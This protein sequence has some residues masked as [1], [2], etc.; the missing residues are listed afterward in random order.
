MQRF[1]SSS[2]G[3][4]RTVNISLWTLCILALAGLWSAFAMGTS[5]AEPSGRADI[6]TIDGLK[7]FGPLERAP[8][9]FLH[10]KHTEVVARQKKDCLVCHPMDGDRLSLR[11]QR[12][13]DVSRQQVMDLYHDQCIACH[14]EYRRLG[15]RSGPV[16]CGECH[17][18]GKTIKSDRR[19]IWLDRSLHYR[20]VKACQDK[21]ETCHHEYNA[22]TKKLY[23]AKGQEGACIYCHK[24]KTEENRISLRLADH[25]AC[26]GCHRNL[27]NEHKDAGPV[28][29]SGCHDPRKQALIKKVKDPPRIARNQPDA[30]LVKTFPPDEMPPASQERLTAVPFNHEAHEGYVNQCR[31]CHHA[32][33]SSC[34]GCHT[35]Q[36]SADGQMV[37]LAQAMHQPDA[38]MSC[39]GC[40]RRQQRRPECYGCHG[41]IPAQRV[42][43]SET[44][45]RTCHVPL[46]DPLPAAA[47]EAQTRALAAQMVKDRPQPP[48]P[49][50]A[51]DIPETVAI[52]HLKDQFDAVAMPHRKIVMAL[53]DIAGDDPMARVFHPQAATV[54]QGCH[55]NSPPSLKPPKCGACH[56]RSSDTL[57]PDRPGLMAAF[58][59]QCFDCHRRMEIEKPATRDCVACHAK[60]AS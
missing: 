14:N 56:G 28:S 50:A 49:V 30:L 19:P 12:T 44:T 21:C 46:A 43:R 17:V 41:G 26:I 20:H 16:T 59:E 55:H 38:V 57:N 11:Y 42:W 5:G 15:E 33:L 45:C 18:D 25:M 34:A 58:H 37:K 51:A 47:D 60:R 48:A 32:A 22:Q 53:T 10:D 1:M 31:T 27:L 40:H 2:R 36:G 9:L 52:D 24:E 6:I 35:I 23:Y 29:C 39:V 54:C 13:K 7:A 3:G 8:V 4:S